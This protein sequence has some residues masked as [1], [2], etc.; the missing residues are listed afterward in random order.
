[1]PSPDATTIRHPPDDTTAPKVMPRQMPT[2]DP[3][4][5]EPSPMP[6]A[7]PPHVDP[8]APVVRP[9]PPR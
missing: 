1:M 9:A 8:N 2:K 7:P 5:I 6:G 4:G 3:R